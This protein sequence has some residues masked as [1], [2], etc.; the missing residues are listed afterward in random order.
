MCESVKQ[1][2][3]VVFLIDFEAGELDQK[4]VI[5]GFQNLID[6]GIVWELQGFYGRTARQLIDQDLCHT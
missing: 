4:E 5:E 1:F 3:Q 2:D 6:S